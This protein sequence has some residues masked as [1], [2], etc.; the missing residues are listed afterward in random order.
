MKGKVFLVGAG[1]GAPDLITLRAADA[2][3][4]AEVVVYDYLASPEILK[5]APPAAARI[6]AGRRGGGE[7]AAEQDEINRLLIEHARAGR[8]VVRLKGGDPFIF[9]RGGEECE[10]LRAAGVEY[11]I[12]PGV[13]AAIAAPAFA[14]IPL[15]H[16]ERASF[17]VFATGHQDPA[18]D[19]D[20]SV[21][22]AELAH[23]ARGRG[24]LVLLMATARMRE[25]VT[26]MAAGGLPPETPAAAIQWGSTAAQRTVFA[27]IGT[28]ADDVARAGLGA[29]AVIVVG[30]CAALGRELGWIERMPL[31]GRRI[32]V[33]RAAANAGEFAG[34]L[35]ALGA[36]AIEFATIAS[37]PPS[38]YAAL[39]RTIDEIGAFDW[40]VFTSTQGVASFIARMRERGRDLRA[41]SGAAL[42]AIGPATA[43]R[44]GEYALNVAATPREYRAEALI[45]AIGAARI[46]GA[47]IL[48]PRA[49]IARE[50]L[51]DT[52]RRLGAREVVVA[53]AYRTIR[54]DAAAAER[55]VTLLDAG[56]I[57]LAAFTS[58][59]TVDNFVAIVGAA[60]A[61]RAKAAAIGPITAASARAH[62]LEVAVEAKQYTISGLTDAIAGWFAG[63]P[64]A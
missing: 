11:E 21:P 2:L 19:A 29:P 45:E 33:T 25:I 39:D 8:R 50:V 36:E 55:V 42:A 57:D 10:A 37:A 60:A 53:P 51:P 63:R 7:R 49:E 28:L 22:W 6:Y 15:T 40:I 44:L 23:A 62:G 61:R 9:G 13:T 54:P 59:S 38:S 32:L 1:P 26:R 17:V 46:A 16:R 64:P 4:A 56:A 14:G 12:V 34:R 52:L 43:A 41:L 47:R 20:W 58:S 5:F 35:R 24:T 3:R 48:I 18:K 30:E 27:T 31:F